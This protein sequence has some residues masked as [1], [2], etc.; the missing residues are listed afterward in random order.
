MHNENDASNCYDREIPSHIMLCS[1]AFG[2]PK[3]SCIAFGK[4]LERSKYHVNTKTGKSEEYYSHSLRPTFG[5]GQGNSGAGPGWGMVS[6]GL[7]DI[8]EKG[9][10]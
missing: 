7:F 9:E 1:R 6:S 5:I 4:T 8:M 10:N 2:V 3:N